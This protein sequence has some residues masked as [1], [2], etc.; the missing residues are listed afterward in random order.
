MSPHRL[1]CAR[2]RALPALTLALLLTACATPG[3]PPVTERSAGSDLVRGPIGSAVGAP[4]IST[5][6][7]QDGGWLAS[8]REGVRSGTDRTVRWI[9][10]WFG[11]PPT[12][13]HQGLV[14]GRLSL[15]TLWREDNGLDHNLRFR[16]KVDLPNLQEKAYLFIGQ[17]NENDF[18]T[19]QPDAF[20]S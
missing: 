12:G 20:T 11:D 17:D 9:D 2:T 1:P 19:D 3:Q 16:A 15:N 14:H 4:A 6:E 18:I 10:S 5:A 8:F 7:P 13:S